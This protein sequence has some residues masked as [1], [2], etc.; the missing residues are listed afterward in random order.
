[1]I[2][3]FSAVV[4]MLACL[5]G[6]QPARC[7]SPAKSIGPKPITLPA[8]QAE[9]A[10]T[11]AAVKAIIDK[12]ND[13]RRENDLKNLAV[14]AD[15]TLAARHFAEFMA[16]NAKY[17][18]EVDGRNA[19]ERAA[20]DGYAGSMIGENIAFQYDAAGF[21]TKRLADGFFEGWK[22]SPEHRANMLDP[23]VT[24]TGLAIVQ[25]E[26][27]GYF[28]AVQLVGR[29]KSLN[30]TFEVKNQS[31]KS[32]ECRLGGD[33]FSVAANSKRMCETS[34]PEVL[35]I[36]FPTDKKKNLTSRTVTMKPANG[37]HLVITNGNEGFQIKK[38]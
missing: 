15:L 20:M 35:I 13:F 38:E 3:Y 36:N 2:R 30:I 17:G 22:K 24:D 11:A 7:Q 29:P 34:R 26:V 14:N 28:Y 6:L 31:E 19:D 23:D 18:H 33:K 27:N 37:D 10:D 21:T 12:T 9:V 4:A 32:I 5:A 25:S 1:V 8:P 16:A